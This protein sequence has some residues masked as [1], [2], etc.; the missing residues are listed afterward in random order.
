MARLIETA[1]G[2]R[3]MTRLGDAMAPTRDPSPREARVIDV[4]RGL[5]RNYCQLEPRRRSAFLAEARKLSTG[6]ERGVATRFTPPDHPDFAALMFLLDALIATEAGVVVTKHGAFSPEEIAE[7]GGKL[8]VEN[9]QRVLV[10]PVAH[11]WKRKPNP[12]TGEPGERGAPIY[13]RPEDRG[14]KVEHFR[15]VR[16]GEVAAREARWLEDE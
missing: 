12:D 10:F 4:V 11:P 15:T 16:S 9:G 8:V 1:S 5:A 2:D 13:R 3:P 6:W 14:P 7:A